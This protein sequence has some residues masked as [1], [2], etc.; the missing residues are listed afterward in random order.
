VTLSQSG[1]D[2]SS[3]DDARR[4]ASSSAG[5]PGTG[6]VTPQR[7]PSEPHGLVRDAPVGQILHLS[8]QRPAPGI[9]VVKMWGEVDLASVP[10]LNELIRQRLTAAV[11]QALV[12][13]LSEVTFL[14]SSGIELLLH[15]QRRAENRGI[16]MFVISG[17]RAVDRM[18]ELTG[19][20]DR[21]TLR[22]SIAE[23]VAA[24]RQ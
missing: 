5:A 14:S 7:L 2:A 15:A 21:F 24:A 20:T 13:D 3:G 17:A 9:A 11:M 22:S 8:V 12:L 1:A 16:A 6:L 10:R 19:L 23:A 18:L 4:G